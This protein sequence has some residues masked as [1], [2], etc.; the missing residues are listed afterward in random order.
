MNVIILPI[1]KLNAPYKEWKERLFQTVIS[2]WMITYREKSKYY[3]KWELQRNL[4]NQKLRFTETL[5]NLK[6]FSDGT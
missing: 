2:Y 3:N 4:L 5:L 6:I 1:T